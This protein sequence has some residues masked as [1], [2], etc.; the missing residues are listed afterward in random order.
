[1]ECPPGRVS[2][3]DFRQRGRAEK[4]WMAGTSPAMTWRGLPLCRG[5][6]RSVAAEPV[7]ALLLPIAGIPVVDVGELHHE[8][9]GTEMCGLHCVL[10]QPYGGIGICGRKIIQRF[11]RP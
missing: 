6:R 8:P 4:T 7:V 1:M 11:S 9:H 2:V 3:H 5:R 10:I